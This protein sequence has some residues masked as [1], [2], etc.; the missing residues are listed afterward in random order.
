MLRLAVL[1]IPLWT[2]LGC[3]GTAGST[4]APDTVELIFVGDIMLDELPGE[5]IDRGDDPFAHFA[6]LF[7]RADVVIGNLE[8]V[9]AT[10]GEPIWKPYTFRANPRCIPVVK[11]HF[12][13][14]SV[15]NNHSGDFGKEALVEELNL[16][17]AAQLPYFGAGRNLAEAHRPLIIER[18]GL[19]IALLGYNEFIPRSFAAGPDTPGCA[20]SHDEEVVADIQAARSVHHADL[21]IPFM[22]WGW[23]DEPDPSDRQR[24]LARRMIDAG[25]DI[26][27]GAHPHVTE[28]TEYYKG[29]LIVY[30]LGNFVFNGF[31]T[32]AQL[33]GWVLRL[34]LNKNG[35]KSWDTL[36][37]KLDDEGLPQPAPN[38]ASPRSG[39]GEQIIQATA[40]PSLNSTLE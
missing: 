27:V 6:D 7:H 32:E 31:E 34:R 12:H 38:V 37:A 21:V 29:H 24:E 26:V 40:D 18:K 11:R 28:G 4:A 10:S 39:P 8:C 33:H 23:E 30:S 25:A 13:A 2:L 20:W 14:V 19:R 17:D 1:L 3:S 5:V 36:V 9:V 15:A 16:L 22:H 35:L